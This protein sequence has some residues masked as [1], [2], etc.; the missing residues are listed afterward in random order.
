MKNYADQGGNFICQGLFIQ[1]IPP[2]V[3]LGI[4][5]GGV[6]PGSSNPDLI[7]DQK[8]CFATPA[9]LPPKSKPVQI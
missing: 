6:P 2:G 3:P 9:T 7:L 1:L 4:L 5:G 8:M